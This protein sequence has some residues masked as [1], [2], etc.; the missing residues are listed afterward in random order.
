LAEAR[1]IITQEPPRAIVLD[2]SLPDGNG[3]DFL[4]ELR[5]TSTIP[6]LMLTAMDTPED[7]IKGLEAGGDD[8]LTKPYDIDIFLARLETLLRRASLLPETLAIGLLKLDTASGTAFLNG[9]D[10]LLSKKE[11][12]LLQLFM[13][14]PEKTMSAEYIYEKVWGQEML[15]NTD[16]L[17]V[18]IYRVRKKLEGSGYTITSERGEGYIFENE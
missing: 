4:H 5:K 17:K 8:Y 12:S 15:A 6:V 3:L 7:M 9:E 16:T 2:I 13:Q 1:A 18:T 14:H 10:M 11:Y